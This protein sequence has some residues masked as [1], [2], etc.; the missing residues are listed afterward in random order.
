MAAVIGVQPQV[1]AMTAH[2]ILS[3]QASSL[4]SKRVCRKE[5]S[6]SEKQSE[7]VVAK[8]SLAVTIAV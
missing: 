6:A 2:S 1:T 3:C 8:R 7:L 5:M 4:A